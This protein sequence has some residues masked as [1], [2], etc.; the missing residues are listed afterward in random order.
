MSLQV[1]FSILSIAGTT[2]SASR[3]CFW[4]VSQASNW[5]FCWTISLRHNRAERRGL[6]C[7][8]AN[9]AKPSSSIP[10][11]DAGRERATCKNLF[12]APWSHQSTVSCLCLQPR[13][14]ADPAS[15]ICLSHIGLSGLFLHTARPGCPSP[16]WSLLFFPTRPGEGWDLQ[17]KW[18]GVN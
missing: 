3:C 8:L 5:I 4:L 17:V 13:A 7:Y 14:A 2:T 6:G 16:A 9:T 12:K 11:W 18:S 10:Q 1:E 15:P